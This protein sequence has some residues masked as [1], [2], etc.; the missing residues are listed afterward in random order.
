MSSIL[1]ER[2]GKAK[3]VW[4]ETGTQR[5]PD[6]VEKRSAASQGDAK[7]A[8]KPPANTSPPSPSRRHSIRGE[9]ARFSRR[10]R[11]PVGSRGDTSPRNQ[12]PW[13]TASFIA[14]VAGIGAPK[15]AG[16][17]QPSRGPRGAKPPDGEGFGEPKFCSKPANGFGLIVCF[18][19]WG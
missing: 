6:Q 17:A 9:P 16:E 18:L 15:D 7:Q 4:L 5:E 3:I 13:A 1:K 12:I 11:S 19:F 10:G 2:M 8:D 14:R